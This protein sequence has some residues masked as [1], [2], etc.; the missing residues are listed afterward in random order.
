M[1]DR[2]AT[3]HNTPS[4]DLVQNWLL[5]SAEEESNFTTLEFTR[6]FTTCDDKDRDIKVYDYSN[7]Y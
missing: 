1:Q 7:N 5:I 6:N 2:Y 4:V 3:G